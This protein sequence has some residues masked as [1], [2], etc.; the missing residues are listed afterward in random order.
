MSSAALIHSPKQK[1]APEGGPI[2]PCP[3]GHLFLALNVHLLPYM[4]S[5]THS[6]RWEAD[7]ACS[8][9]KNGYHQM[10]GKGSK[11]ERERQELGWWFWWQSWEVMRSA[12]LHS[13]NA[14]L[15]K[16]GSSDV[17]NHHCSY[18]KD[19]LLFPSWPHIPH[20]LFPLLQSCRSSEPSASQ[21]GLLTQKKKIYFLFI[22]YL[23]C[24]LNLLTEELTSTRNGSRLLAVV[25]FGWQHVLRQVQQLLGILQLPPLQPPQ[26]VTA[27]AVPLPSP[28]MVPVQ[29]LLHA[30]ME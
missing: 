29:V 25:F 18:A 12:L 13:L 16:T 3:P 7:S 2:L 4:G 27:T 22:S 14:K 9:G 21:F 23:T 5:G 1:V 17:T 28:T 19:L 20:Y 6:D 30:L 15:C 24:K 26:W 10:R 8:T 11:G